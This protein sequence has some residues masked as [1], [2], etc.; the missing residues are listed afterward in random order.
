MHRFFIAKEYLQ[1]DPI[2]LPDAVAHQIRSVLRM[3]PGDQVQVLD[4]LG[5]VYD[6]RLTAVNRQVVTGEL[7]TQQL[8]SSEPT[9][10][11]TLYQSLLKRDK[12]EWVLQKCTELGVTRFV[13]VITQRS[14]VTM[15]MKPSKVARWQRIIMEAAEQSQRGH[16]PELA[17]AVAFTDALAQAAT[18]DCLL[19]P[20]VQAQA[21]SIKTALPLTTK[22]V[23]LFIGPEGGFTEVEAHRSRQTG[24]QLVT[25]GPRILRAETAAVSATT[26]ILATLGDMEAP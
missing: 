3:V 18:Y 8:V 14:V 22:K 11:I 9:T 1:T 10:E 15:P 7:L 26:L 13:P 25:L 23:A 5:W 6:V 16:L 19:M 2:I 20:W 4:N 21:R 24:V 12:F 17:T